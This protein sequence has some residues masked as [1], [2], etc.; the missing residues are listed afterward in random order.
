MKK[1]ETRWHSLIYIGSYSLYISPPSTTGFQN[2]PSFNFMNG[3]IY[4][5]GKRDED[6]S[7]TEALSKIDFFNVQ[8]THRRGGVDNKKKAERKNKRR[9]HFID[10][11]ETSSSPLTGMTM[12]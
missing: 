7:S 4:F 2:L 10:G 3:Y 1:R 6:R 5:K 8:C 9:C 11:D 12:G